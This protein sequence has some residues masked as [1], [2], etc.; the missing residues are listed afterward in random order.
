MSRANLR[1]NKA[2]WL[3]IIGVLLTA[4]LV[5]WLIFTDTSEEQ[6]KVRFYD[7]GQGDAALITTPDGYNVLVDGG[8]NNKVSEYLNHDLPINDRSL[9]LVIL[10]HPQSDHMYGLINVIKNFE[11]KKIITSNVSHTTSEYKLWIDTVNNQGLS[12]IYAKA[13]DTLSLGSNTNIRFNWP[14]TNQPQSVSDLNTASLVFTLSYNSLDI[15]M[16]GD[17]DSQVQPYD[18]NFDTVEVLK[19]PHHGSKTALDKDFLSKINP[20]V[21]IISSGRN[22]RYGHPHEDLVEQLQDIKT[23]IFRTDQEGTIEIVSDGKIWYTQRENQIQNKF[24]DAL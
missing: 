19:V 1:S 10:T 16:T 14:K 5:V 2:I 12:L 13:G 17:A 3:L 21:S 4:N 18:N 11:V 20:K 7:V 6:F 8:P 15:L 24:T 23:K 9:D 22:N